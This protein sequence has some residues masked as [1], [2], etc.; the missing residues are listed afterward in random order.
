VTAR[1]EFGHHVDHLIAPRIQASG[2]TM[3]ES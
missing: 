3:R 2:S 1:T